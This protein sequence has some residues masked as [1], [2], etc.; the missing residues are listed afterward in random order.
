M[1]K[2]L[3]LFLILL[4]FGPPLLSAD[5]HTPVVP[6]SF[7]FPAPC[8]PAADLKSDFEQARE[9][10]NNNQ[11]Q[12]AL[13]ILLRLLKEDPQNSNLNFL[14][15]YCYYNI[16]PERNKALPYLEKAVISTVS[17]YDDNSYKEKSA[18]VYAF[19]YLGKCY[20]WV[21][22]LEAALLNLEKFRAFLVNKS[23]KLINQKNFEIFNE[24]NA[25]IEQV[26]NAQKFISKPVK[27]EFVKIPLINTSNYSCFGPQL[28]RDGTALY[29]SREKISERIRG[30]SDMYILR[31]QGKNWVKSEAVGQFLNGPY[32]DVFNSI[33]PDN[34][35]LLYASDRKG[36]FNVFYSMLENN[37]W[38]EPFDNLSINSNFNETYAALSGDGN[39]MFFV[40]DRPGGFGGKDIYKIEKR[41]DGSWTQPENLGFTVNTSGD[42][43]TPWLS[44]DGNSLYFSSSGHTTMGGSDI[45]YT[46]YKNNI[47][48]E[49]VNMGY[50][51]NS[52]ANDLYFKYY[53]EYNLLLLSSN[54]ETGSYSYD[55]LGARYPDS[56]SDN[57]VFL[58]GP[59]MNVYDTIRE[60]AA[61][62]DDNPILQ[63][64]AKDT[65]LAEQTLQKPAIRQPEPEKDAE[66]KPLIQSQEKE[67][68]AR[69]D[70]I[71]KVRQKQV[72][73]SLA[74]A[75]KEAIKKESKIT[76]S[77]NV[78]ISAQMKQD[79]I[80]KVRELERK[81][82][83]A[84]ATQEKLKQLREK[85]R[86]DSVVNAKRLEDSLK[87]AAAKLAA[88]EKFKL[89]QQMAEL[90][91]SD[92]SA[93]V[94]FVS[95]D[96][97]KTV[98]EAIARQTFINDSITRV[99][100]IQD[101]VSVVL[102]RES[103]RLAKEQAIAAAKAK[104]DSLALV[105]Q[106]PD[107]SMVAAPIPE[108]G[109]IKAE[110]GWKPTVQTADV[111]DSIT[112]SQAEV[113]VKQEVEVKSETKTLV[114]EQQEL[115]EKEKMTGFKPPVAEPPLEQPP[116][117]ESPVTQTVKPPVKE[118]KVVATTVK[119]QNKSVYQVQ[120]GG[121]T[122]PPCAGNDTVKR[123]TVQVGAG[124]MKIKYFK[125]I[126][127]K[128]ICYGPDGLARF[129]V[130]VFATRKEAEETAEQLRLLGFTDAWVPPV[131][132][133]RCICPDNKLLDLSYESG[134]AQAEDTKYTVQ[135]G[136]GN[137]K[138]RYFKA[139]QQ[140]NACSGRDGLTRFTFGVF[141]TLDE[142][143]KAKDK[144]KK[145][146]FP[147]AW[148]PPIDE[149]RCGQ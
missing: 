128:K 49:P 63:Q 108:S 55:I 97:L 66:A 146:G 14:V 113:A 115:A 84:Q 143:Q 59:D 38:S 77:Q 41:S 121:E 140:V 45:F 47:W 93:A 95:S 39:K 27:I 52:V 125:N 139:L 11:Y 138:I 7:L 35:F 17:D 116:T 111:K 12:D 67:I 110:P 69:Q 44:D 42:E 2:F 118:D 83:L 145:L 86:N 36:A 73:D 46:T 13:P 4:V 137:M 142:A 64:I 126:D 105:Q 117:V 102:A 71:I 76:Q 58:P 5:I 123:Y 141:N 60:I 24:V 98:R 22:R 100:R 53:R 101:S 119:P 72:S 19:F 85:A 124:W 114:T 51:I 120:K 133:K 29:Y 70:S 134:T 43:D 90:A 6:V 147:D 57:E 61:E 15:G 104:A 96:S 136:A 32:N 149:N 23:D 20:H 148:T 1:R 109:I 94:T 65:S 87:V 54:R 82:A 48:L 33:S 107:S 130:G 106:Q 81:K 75:R 135:V 34:K 40:S 127:Q 37:K 16:E 89:S 74:A 122:L 92:T 21:G 132:E 25:G 50:P 144:I 30:K 91:K 31:R 88:K 9:L 78:S 28:T 8:A 112:V 18:P 79:S 56:T 103:A 26:K 131:D 62:K 68:R 129:I 80:A 99:K 10:I 3:S